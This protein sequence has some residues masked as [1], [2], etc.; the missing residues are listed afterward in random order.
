VVNVLYPLGTEFV[1]GT[2]VRVDNSIAMG[3]HCRSRRHNSDLSHSVLVSALKN[4]KHWVSELQV[5]LAMLARRK[6]RTYSIKPVLRYH[7]QIP[8]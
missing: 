2:E 7:I 6:P 4:L 1:Y 5:A 8:S 3:F